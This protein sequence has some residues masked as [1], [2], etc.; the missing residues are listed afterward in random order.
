MHERVQER[1][2]ER[3]QP[4][5]IERLTDEAPEQRSEAPGSQQATLAQ[6]RASVLR[7]LASLFNAVAHDAD[8]R[9]DVYPE[10]RRSAMN[11]GLP[12]LAGRVASTIELRSLE[13][14]LR[15][16]VLRFEPRLL[17]DSV[18]VSVLD[19]EPGACGHN[20]IAFRIEAQ[21]WAQPAPVAFSL[22]T[23]LDLESGQCTVA[24]GHLAR[25]PR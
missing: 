14:E 20:V 13:R 16:A 25:W 15:L 19:D 7:N 2:R 6:L 21:L 10:V 5:L 4:S 22:H 12:A 1:V 11:F 18:R 3:L 17:S 8:R 9:L 23:R 24:E